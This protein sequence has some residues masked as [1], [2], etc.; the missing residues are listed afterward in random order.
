MKLQDGQNHDKVEDTGETIISVV[1]L[2]MNMKVFSELRLLNT[3]TMKWLWCR[4]SI[5][6]FQEIPYKENTC[7]LPIPRT[8][9][10]DINSALMHCMNLRQMCRYSS[11][12]H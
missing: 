10:V 9:T 3:A 12:C 5:G 4:V 8:R 11:C 6:V 1:F 7:S 2:A